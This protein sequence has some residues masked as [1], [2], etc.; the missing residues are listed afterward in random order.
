MSNTKH[1]AIE[2]AL[3]G[4]QGPDP[5]SWERI[6]SDLFRRAD[7]EGLIDVAFERHDSPLGTIVLG[8]TTAGLVRVGLPIEGEDAVLEELARRPDTRADR[9]P[10]PPRHRR[11]RR[12]DRLRRPP[13]TQASACSTSKPAHSPAGHPTR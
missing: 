5:T 12:P 8:A 2:A 9:H 4:G 3:T 6:R 10:L 7:A 13:R 11:R 1:T